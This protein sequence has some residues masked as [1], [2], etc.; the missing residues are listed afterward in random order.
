[1]PRFVVDLGDIPMS[2][3]EEIALSDEI[4]RV[5]MAHVA[6]LRFDQ[7]IAVRFP[8]EWLGIILRKDIAVL[9][10]A[11]KALNKTLDQ[12]PGGIAAQRG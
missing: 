11:E 9:L 5:A 8:W 7:P 1:M 12:L 2:K 3:S 4:Q 10:D 6:R